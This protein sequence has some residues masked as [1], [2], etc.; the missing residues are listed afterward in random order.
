MVSFNQDSGFFSHPLSAL[1]AC[2][3]GGTNR[4]VSEKLCFGKTT[5]LKKKL[6]RAD[7]ICF[8]FFCCAYRSRKNLE[9]SAVAHGLRG[10]VIG[11]VGVG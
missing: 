11:S 1:S 4:D 5:Y 3:G 10:Y 8:C 9:S 7:L 2:V 6:T